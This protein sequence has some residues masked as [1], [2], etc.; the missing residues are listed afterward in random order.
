MLSSEIT[1]S[2]DSMMPGLYF[3]KISEDGIGKG[4][5]G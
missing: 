2:N 3:Y 4:R 1:V 5:T